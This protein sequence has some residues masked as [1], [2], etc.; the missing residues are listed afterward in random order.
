MA[1]TVVIG[2]VV[3]LVTDTTAR[4]LLEIDEP[5]EVTIHI[6]PAP[7]QG[8]EKFAR[9]VSPAPVSSTLSL[10]ANAPRAF[11]FTKLTSDTRFFLRIEG[12]SI[13]EELRRQVGSLVTHGSF[14]THPADGWNLTQGRLPS[15]AAVSCNKIYETERSVGKNMD[16]WEDLAAKAEAGT[17]DMALHLGDVVYIDSGLYDFEH[18]GKKL[19]AG[20]KECAW[21]V[22]W[23]MVEERAGGDV[24]K[25]SNELVTEITALFRSVWH[26]TFSHKPTRVALANM[27]NL[28]IFD[29]HEIRDD[30]GDRPEDSEVGPFCK[31]T[32]TKS[33]INAFLG[34]LAYRL[35]LEYQRQLWQD[36]EH[37]A[38][39]G[40]DFHHWAFGDVG[41]AFV[42]VRGCKSFYR[43]GDQKNPMLG[44]DQWTALEAAVKPTGSFGSCKILLVCNPLP[45][46]YASTA[47]T[48]EIA[49]RFSYGDD[50]FGSW[51]HS[52]HVPEMGRFLDLFANWR[53]KVACREVLFVG[54]DVHEA[55]WSDLI[56]CNGE[57]Q[58]RQL[59]TSA[60]ANEVPS[61]GAALVTAVIRQH[62]TYLCDGWDMFHDDWVRHRNYAMISANL[63]SGVAQCSAHLVYADDG[64]IHTTKSE[65]TFNKS[66]SCLGSFCAR[67]CWQK[68]QDGVA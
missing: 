13:A 58:V 15:F 54:G 47:A 50:M 30:W 68:S 52:K 32:S 10:A 18:D 35:I 36:V 62:R 61:V 24:S 26:R 8:N 49:K 4:V 63:V 44:T 55:G 41:I 27:G 1:P 16:L 28:M 20:D 11:E 6:S 39:P 12:A 2:P 34:R 46:A 53:N 38:S 14:H 56:P 65:T 9:K 42:D 33:C 37:P 7:L 64:G 51:S 3:G 5:A 21:L 45:V 29:D 25:V 57:R 19:V 31:Q 23:K 43:S 67:C 66:S 48:D 60:I 17:I 40:P 59:T 22:A